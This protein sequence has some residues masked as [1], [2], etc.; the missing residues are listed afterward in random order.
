MTAERAHDPIGSGS[1]ASR[2]PAQIAERPFDTGQPLPSRTRAVLE[3]RLG[4]SFADVRVH[5]DAQAADSAQSLAARAYTTGSEIVFGTG[6]YAPETR[7]GRAL[8]AHELAHVVQ[9]RHGDATREEHSA[10][11]D[12]AEAEATRA[13]SAV[14]S[15]RS[16]MPSVRAPTS[17]ARQEV[18]A[19]ATLPAPSSVDVPSQTA[20]KPESTE[21][22]ADER[23]LAEERASALEMVRTEQLEFARDRV[24]G[25]SLAVAQQFDR[26]KAKPVEE[27]PPYRASITALERQLV[28]ALKASLPVLERQVAQLQ[29]RARRGEDVKA[30][31]A[32][33]QK[34]LVDNKADLDR[35]GGVFTPEKE[36]AF[37]KAYETKLAGAMCMVR[38]YEGLGALHS[39]E[40]A[41]DLQ[42]VVETQARRTMKRT[43]VD[44]NHFITVM[45]AA[46]AAKMAGPRNRARWRK[47]KKTWTPTLDSIIG[48]RISSKVPA[49]YFFGLALAEAYH[50]VIV[51]VSTWGDARETLW[52]D[53]SG[54]EKVAGSLDDFARAKAEGYAISYPDWDTYIWQI[55][56]PAEASLLAKPPEEQK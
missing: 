7:A 37:E 22:A 36:S 27:R 23:A 44:T 33:A 21:A 18:G 28:Q 15:G 16:F 25:A 41:A 56:P 43:K 48:S 35:L 3:R 9:Q 1:T 24:D 13:G 54:C 20:A 8:L 31:V 19:P 50:S 12:I 52:C 47:S 10:Q 34:E 26:M 40:K 46:N 49:F 11:R 39:P 55:V 14:A 51:G 53:Q 30:E 5:T 32:A 38:A 42:K 29:A 17:V 2:S 45:N 6:E 4:H